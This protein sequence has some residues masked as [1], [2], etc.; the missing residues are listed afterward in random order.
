MKIKSLVDVVRDGGNTVPMDDGEAKTFLQCQCMEMEQPDRLLSDVDGQDLPSAAKIIGGRLEW[1]G[2]EAT[3]WCVLMVAY[4]CDR[5]GVAVMWAYTL[6]HM[7]EIKGDAR[8]NMGDVA[9]AFPCGFPD[10]DTYRVCWE[11]QKGDR[12]N[13]GGNRMDDAD[14]W[15]LNL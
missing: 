1:S 4:L 10:G 5:P 13:G 7:A 15:K 3:L 14:L 8:V 11:A 6:S 9:N 12:T 2:V